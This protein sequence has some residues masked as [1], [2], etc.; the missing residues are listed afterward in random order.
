[1]RFF[2]AGLVLL[3]L[4]VQ[5]AC[6]PAYTQQQGHELAAQARLTDTIDMRRTN[7]RVL[8]R[9]AQ[10][11]LVSSVG[12]TAAGATFLRAMQEGFSGHFLAVGVES[13]S[14]DFLRAMA[15]PPC[16]GASYL[17]YIQ[18]IGSACGGSGQTCDKPPSQFTLTV[19]SN[20]DHSL[21]DRIDVTIKRSVIPG[22]N[23]S[24]RLEKS[25]EQLAAELTGA[26]GP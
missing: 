25:F 6:T 9:Q 2:K 23:S 16:P 17:F 10:V 12:G 3:A 19:V 8:S 7:Q 21:V 4:I 13:E 26:A 22:G 20:G 5:A 14:M 11:C 1:M 18:P 15:N 24:E